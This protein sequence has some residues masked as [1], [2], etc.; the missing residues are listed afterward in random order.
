MI[1]ENKKI[2]ETKLYAMLYDKYVYN[3][4]E[5]ALDPLI[6]N[7]NFRTAIKDYGG[8]EFNT[9]DNKIK[10]DVTYLINNLQKKF[11]YTEKGAK[12]ISIYVID[13]DLVNICKQ[14]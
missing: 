9:Y 7:N 14:D 2:H 4:K 10:H 6:T 11:K 13:K 5:K 1:V 12:D 3:I 8:V